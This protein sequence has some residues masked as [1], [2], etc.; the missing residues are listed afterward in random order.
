[1][2]VSVYVKIWNQNGI[3]ISKE[4]NRKKDEEEQVQVQ[5]NEALIKILIYLRDASFKVSKF[6]SESTTLA[7]IGLVPLF[8][9][10]LFFFFILSS[11]FFTTFSESI[12]STHH[13][14]VSLKMVCQGKFIAQ[15]EP[16]SQSVHRG[17]AIVNDSNQKNIKKGKVAS[18]L[19]LH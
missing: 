19:K 6:D 16:S 1:M 11:I 13:W 8:S 10:V 2:S 7:W 15:K 5:V 4:G 14:A 17:W 3:R 18:S 9:V 12:F